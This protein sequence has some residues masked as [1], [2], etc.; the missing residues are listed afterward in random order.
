[1]LNKKEKARLDLTLK[2]SQGTMPIVLPVPGPRLEDFVKAAN[3]R[4][5]AQLIEIKEAEL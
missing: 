5:N 4:K 3:G 1:M 2:H